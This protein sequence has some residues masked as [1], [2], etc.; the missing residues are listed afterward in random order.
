M[1]CKSLTLEKYVC[2]RMKWFFSPP[3]LS[4]SPFLLLNLARWQRYAYAIALFTRPE[5]KSW[6]DVKICAHAQCVLPRCSLG[7]ITPHMRIHGMRVGDLTVGK[8]YHRFVTLG[9]RGFFFLLLA[10]KIERRSCDRD[11]REKNPLHMAVTHLT[12]TSTDC[13][14]GRWLVFEFSP[15]P[16]RVIMI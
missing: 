12:S 5:I 4:V 13:E 6:P 1:W 15:R 16:F 9:A 2:Y 3:F 14:L 7:P 11:E 8:S 10:A